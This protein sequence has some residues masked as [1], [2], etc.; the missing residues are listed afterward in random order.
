MELIKENQALK[1]LQGELEQVK[2]ERDAAV[3]DINN[4]APCF[5]CKNFT[6]NNGDC[7]GA[8]FCSMEGRPEFEKYPNGFEWRK[9]EGR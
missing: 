6:R 1:S 9:M 7:F 2:L 8:N 5:A 4:S 3:D